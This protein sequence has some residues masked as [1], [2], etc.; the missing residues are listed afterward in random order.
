MTILI[1]QSA[2]PNQTSHDL[3][4]LA[5][6]NPAMIDTYLPSSQPYLLRVDGQIRGVC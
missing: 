5:D 1:S 6:E 2:Q 3:L 4:L